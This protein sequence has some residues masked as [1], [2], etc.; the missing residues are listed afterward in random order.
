MTKDEVLKLHTDQFLGRSQYG[1]KTPHSSINFLP[2][3]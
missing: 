1:W 2:I 3:R